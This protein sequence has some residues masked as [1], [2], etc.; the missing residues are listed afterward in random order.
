M[1][2]IYSEAHELHAPKT[3]I[4]RGVVVTNPE[5]M[6]RGR[7]L[8]TNVRDAG[9]SISTPDD[10][11]PAS[12]AAVHTP[13]YLEFLET[14]W[15]RWRS[16][17]G[18]GAE[19]VSN[20]HAS[21]NMGRR[22]EGPV[23][24]VG[25]HTA[26]T[27]CPIVAGTWEAAVAGANCAVHAAELILTGAPVVYALCRP[28]GHHAYT[29]MAG[30]FCYLNNVAIAAQH[31]RRGGVD[32]VAI[33]DVDVHH[34]NGT[35]GIFYERSDVFTVSLHADTA[36]YCPFFAG[37]CDERGAGPGLG[38][39]LNLSLP[40]GTGD[41]GVLV[42][43][44]DCIGAI[45]RYAPDALLISLGFDMSEKDPLGIMRV[46][47]SGFGEMA[48]RIGDLHLPTVL[49]QEGGYM[50]DVLGANLVSFLAAYQGGSR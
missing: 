21:R 34:G 41:A 49:V 18:A 25:Y 16:L 32:R 50:S 1:E 45:R 2:V 48:K 46:T 9:H 7:T 37:Y 24:L 15:D 14:I 40:H 44:N 33:L 23:G 28:P 5:V 27:A 47:T 35:Q 10:F 8:V 19:I 29:D 12:R 38:Y 26:D 6:E 17:D 3:F 43:L 36:D 39:S 4:Q 22:P 30:G 31:M 20:V 42:A 13:E 11:G